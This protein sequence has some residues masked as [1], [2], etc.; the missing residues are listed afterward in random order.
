MDIIYDGGMRFTIHHRGHQVAIDA[1]A[2]TP[3][4]TDTG[5]LPTELFAATLGACI[6][7]YALAYCRKHDLPT[8]GLRV[9]THFEQAEH[10]KRIARIVSTLIVPASI[11]PHHLPGIQAMAK[12]CIIHNTL[13]HPV[14]TPIT[15]L[16][17]E[18]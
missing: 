3:G 17:D 7:Y 10:P 4:G 14:E 18:L 11:D 2:T 12:A 13:N 9:E 16:R 5:L 6:G 8:E 1:P 15:V